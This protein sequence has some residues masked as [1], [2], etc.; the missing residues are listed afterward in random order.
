MLVS[1]TVAV[2]L[3]HAPACSPS[4]ADVYSQ[5]RFLCLPECY[6]GSTLNVAGS[7][8][9]KVADLVCQ[10]V[11][12]PGDTKQTCGAGWYLQLYKSASAPGISSKSS[13]TSSRTSSTSSAAIATPTGQWTFSHCATDNPAAPEGGRALTGAGPLL[14]PAGS[15]GMTNVLCQSMCEARGFAMAGTEY[16]SECYCG[17]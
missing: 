3:D 11:V 2:R 10:A 13:S 5:S 6:C 7:V 4:L 8:G 12:C 9:S 1:S 14:A 16:R 17:K 15:K